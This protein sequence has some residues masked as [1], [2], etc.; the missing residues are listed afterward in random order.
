MSIECANLVKSYGRKEIIKDISVSIREGAITGLIGPNGAGK[1]T[2]IKLITGLVHPDSGTVLIDGYD[3]SFEHIRAMQ[4]LGAVVEWSSFYP[5]LTARQNLM[6]LSGGYGRKYR[7]KV[8]EVT[9]F[10]G[11]RDVL[12]RKTGTFSTGMKQRLGIALALL[13]DSKYIILDEPANGL[14]PAGIVEIRN[15]IRECR[16]QAGVTVLVSSHL[17]GEME[18]ICDDVIMIVDG[19]LRA[20]GELKK[21]LHRSNQ[22]RVVTSGS[23]NC[24]GF[25][26][27][28]Q[29]AGNL[30]ITS[31]TEHCGN[32]VLFT[33][34]DDAP[35]QSV[36]DALF[37]NGFGIVHFSQEKCSLEEFFISKSAASHGGDL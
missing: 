7:Q 16:E 13:P 5:D 28:A 9:G 22:Y 34:E 1:S 32:S 25:L 29:L 4:H 23:G 10:L 6:I 33:L 12:D 8:E 24:Y 21:L 11:V 30:G 20:S 18:L 2:F 27:R 19:E 35:V 37:K 26:E 36:T 31:V 3:S 14:D 17:L 15:L